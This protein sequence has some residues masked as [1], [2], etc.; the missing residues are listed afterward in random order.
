MRHAVVRFA[1]NFTV[2]LVFG[3]GILAF[4][5]RRGLEPAPFLTTAVAA[6]GVALW[7]GSLTTLI[8]TRVILMAEP[9]KRALAAGV[10]G[11]LSLG[12]FA[13]ILSVV[14]W[15]REEL[16][17]IGIG[18]AAGGLMQ[19]ARAF[20]LGPRAPAPRADGGVES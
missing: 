2:Y 1:L 17:F 12:G 16:G 18:I 6:L 5:A 11:A 7:S 14:A 10:V 19:A 20:S 4:T 8:E 13:A 9:L 15:H 3:G